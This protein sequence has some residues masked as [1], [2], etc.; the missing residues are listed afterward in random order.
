M[1]LR[2][3]TLARLRA[4]ET[5]WRATINKYRGP[6]PL[7]LAVA[8]MVAESNGDEDPTLLDPLRRPVGIMQVSLRDGRKFGYGETVLKD[9]TNNIYV[10]CLKTNKDAQQLKANFAWW[11]EAKYDFWLAVRAAFVLGFPTMM[12]IFATAELLRDA[13]STAAVQTYLRTT[14]KRFGAFSP[15]DLSHLADHLDEVR[16]AMTT[17]DGP[18]QASY[19]FFDAPPAA[20]GGKLALA[21]ATSK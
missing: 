10:W 15:H 19:A 8:S 4:L 2:Q 13:T 18:D 7:G 11:S 21:N 12:R 3:I 14:K 17:I 9:T 20:P 5:K 1:K 16:T 6:A